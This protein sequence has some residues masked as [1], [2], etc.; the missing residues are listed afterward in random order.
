MPAETAYAPRPLRRLLRYEAH[1][2]WNSLFAA[3]A[4]WRGRLRWIV[5][6]PSLL[7]LFHFWL[8]DQP[9]QSAARTA[10]GPAFLLGLGVMRSA[11]KRLAFQRGEGL[12]A[13]QALRRGV[14]PAYFSLYLILSVL[15]LGLTIAV[16]DR[17]LLAACLIAMATGIT[18]GALFN[19]ATSFAVV[20]R[21]W[22]VLMRVAGAWL[23]RPVA[24]LVLAA[25]F[26]ALVFVL[27]RSVPRA[28][29]LPGVGS[30]SFAFCLALTP[31]DSERVRF[32]AQSGFAVWPSL[33]VHLPGLAVFVPVAA[34]LAGLA[35][36]PE[37]AAIVVG[38]AIVAGVFGSLR[39]LAY[40]VYEKWAADL[41]ATA[42]V[43]GLAMIG[44]FAL[45]ALPFA[46]GAA[47]WQLWRRGRAVTWLLTA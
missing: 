1:V 16:L 20:A 21:G 11:S 29:A 44:A 39:L 40:R 30:L 19:F 4:S 43:I 38:A 25:A 10:S 6:V 33:A 42:L 5:G 27:A 15:G 46:L 17:A 47:V 41:I 9:P 35:L 28:V 24:G 37:A 14:G 26:G 22:A 36:G 2:A 7:V 32:M 13:P 12:M 23:Q 31:V 8:A 34:L 3:S 45:P 18:V